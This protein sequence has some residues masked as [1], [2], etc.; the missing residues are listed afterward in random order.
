MIVALFCFLSF[1]NGMQW[2]TFAPIATRFKEVYKLSTFKVNLF[3]MIYMIVYPF[4]NFPASYLIDN[5]SIRL[6]VLYK[7]KI[8]DIYF[9][10]FNCHRGRTEILNKLKFTICLYRAN[11]ISY[12]SAY[13]FKFSWENSIYLV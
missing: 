8:K 12:G 5:K 7:N 13:Y 2:V 6:G 11:F 3:S 9:S 10:Y 4:M 1:S